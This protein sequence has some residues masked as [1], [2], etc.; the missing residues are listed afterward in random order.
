MNNHFSWSSAFKIAGREARAS[1]GKFLFVILAVAAGV[2]A[3][4]SV[5]GFSG[6]FQS[7]LLRDARILMAGDLSV[8]LFNHP[9]PEQQAVFEKLGER[10]VERTWISETISMMSS[11]DSSRP[12]MV[13]VKAVEP[14]RY[15][16]YGE[17]KLSPEADLN[18]ILDAESMIVS[19]DLLLRLNLQRGDS[20]ALGD[21]QFRIVAEVLVE[22]DRMTGTMNIGPRVLISREG[23]DRARLIQ[24]GSRASQRYLFRLPPE[25]IS[26]VE[27]RGVLETAFQGDRIVDFREAHPTLRRGLDRST[28]FLSL[29]S[30]I[31]LIVGALG[32]AM[33]M[34]SHLQQRLDTIAIMKCV[35]GRS[36]QIMR[37]YLLQTISLGLVGSLLGVVIGYGMQTLFPALIANYFPEISALDWQPIVA[38]QGVLI[39]VLTTLLFTVP[40]L[41]SI[42]R[43]RPAVI[44]RRDMDR[45]RL[46]I[47]E[48]L[49]LWLWRGSFWPGAAI[50][51]SIAALAVWLGESVELGAWF[52]GGLVVSLLILSAVASGMLRL[53]RVFPRWLPW[54]LPPSLRQGI[55]NLHRP[56]NHTGAVLVSLGIGVTFTLCIYLIQSSVLSQMVRSAP[57]NMPNVFFINVTDQERDGLLEVLKQ[58]PGIK[59]EPELSPSVAARLVGVD[60]TPIEDMDLGNSSRRFRRTRTITWR[61]EQPENVEIIEGEWW[62][63]ERPAGGR[64]QASAS[65]GIAE[66]LGVKLGS[67]VEW[68]VGG[69]TV[70]AKVVAIHRSERI[71]PGSSIGFILTP[72]ALQ[73]LPATYYGGVRVDPQ[74]AIEL[75]R[76]AFDRFPTITVINAADVLEIVQQVVDQ[77]GLVVRFVS[78]FAILGGII[79]LASGVMATRFRRIREVAILKTLGATRRRVANMFS[80]EFL[81][82]GSVAG[83]TGAILASGFS[84]LLLERVLDAE[85][86]FDA[87]ASG[88]CVVATALLANLAG[89][90]SSF[91][92]LGRKPLE[93]LRGE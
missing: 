73:G 14:D 6:A 28:K 63:A 7:M 22:P 34:H 31:A 47:G 45:A 35:G 30:L 60:A 37:I 75:Q 55:A 86:Q 68:T 71:R 10:G 91:R 54:R 50:L 83:L 56:G 27:A 53:L 1:I 3:L 77:I 4:T 61:S 2:G 5:R 46:T 36:G 66:L 57:P 43:V 18:D 89:W 85:Y 42:R 79:I 25:R 64:H 16:F 20:V 82:L 92:I 87:V 44:F 49:R 40:T 84:G 11:Q 52:A 88:V 38:L 13:A 29:V 39:G 41:L 15:P 23:L 74:Q 33:A 24:P 78:A 65:E 8:R 17:I 69:Q 12:L 62:P 76:I 93:V 32:V 67:Q 72:E 9:T 70:L 21:E 19:S 80:A 59:D 58:T 48:R 90:L 51:A 81:I 26:I